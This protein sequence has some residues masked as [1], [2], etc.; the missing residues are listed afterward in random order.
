MYKHANVAIE[1]FE[2][3]FGI[4]NLVSINKVKN[5]ASMSLR[6]SYSPVSNTPAPIKK[7]KKRGK[8]KKTKRG[9]N[10]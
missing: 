5:L 9:K 6:F 10:I 1:L 3:P 4:G 7:K 2:F 8:E